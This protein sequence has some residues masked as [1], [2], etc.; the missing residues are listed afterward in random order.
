M[1]RVYNP[2]IPPPG[3]ILKRNISAWMSNAVKNSK[4]WETMQMSVYSRMCK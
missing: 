1:H 2:T 3:Y 4:Q